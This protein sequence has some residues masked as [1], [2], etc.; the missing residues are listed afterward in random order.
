[1]HTQHIDIAINELQ[2]CKARWA[3][4]PLS[5]KLVYVNGLR[6]ATYEHSR[7][8][9]ELAVKA[10]GLTMTSAISGE[11]WIAGPFGVIDALNSLEVTLTRVANNTDVLA[12]HT[13]RTRR[14]GQA[15]VDVMPATT[16]E[17]LLFSGSRAEVWMDPTITIDNIRD[18]VAEFYSEEQ[19]EGAVC[20]VMGA[21]NVASIA[22]LDVIY[23][24][25][26]DGE[27]AILK[28]NPVNEYLGEVFENIFADLVAD[29]YVRLV[30]GDGD[31]GDYLV[32]HEGVD[33]IH[34]TGSSST[35]N[36]I[37]YGTG[38]DGIGNR[39]RDTPIN[40]KPISAEL[41][42]VNPTIVVPGDW[43]KADLK[44]QADHV[45]S[46]KMN[47]SGFNC[48][49]AQ[50]LVLP[51]S[52][53][54]TDEFVDEVRSQFASLEDRDAYYPGVGDRCAAVISGSGTVETFGDEHK[55]LL[56]T[57]LDATAIDEAAFLTEYFAPAL[58]IVMLPSPDVTT[59]LDNA[60]TFAN[61]VL[62]GT[63]GA[64]VIIHPKTEKANAA[65]FDKAIEDLRY[66]GIG[67]NIWN[68]AVFLQSRCPWGAYPGHTSADIGS[69]IGV[70]HNTL[71]LSKTQK[72][73]YRAPFAPYHR[74]ATKGE[75]HLAPKPIWY[76]SNKNMHKT[77]E[78]LVDYTATG[79]TGD[80]VKLLAS[81]MRG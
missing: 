37:R 22:P 62:E 73:V 67:I 50:I 68:A 18:H 39:E 53:E 8:W 70:V 23:K 29:G 16:V 69:G 32:T 4:L 13:V 35:Y 63:L 19:P 43:S 17:K 25:F 28:L 3:R 56:I 24:L 54:L 79:E 6:A 10:K 20:A 65:A 40:D 27:V 11:E 71:M 47:N 51:E 30:Y 34:L 75:I 2:A 78:L 49:A 38:E 72:S 52:W 26:N 42:G 21:G 57:D 33:T 64:T 41:G 14:S 36:T 76:L 15:V 74:T 80:L 81:A 66:G 31:V 9:V 59:Y 7:R 77:T 12:G 61:D 55:R 44:F 58:A 1:M 48:V 60:V 45:V 46:Q 5:D